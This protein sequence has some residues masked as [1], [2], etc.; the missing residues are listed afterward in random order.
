M[1]EIKDCLKQYKE[2]TL[3]LINLLEIEDYDSLES[4]LDNRQNLIDEMSQMSYTKETM[5][6]IYEELQIQQLQ[7]KLNIVMNEK[8]EE[9]KANI[10]NLSASKTARKGYTNGFKVDSL[11]LNKK[12]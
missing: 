5:N 11:F 3:K 9:I 4:V 8:R 1:Q 2:I 10:E 6:K 12:I 7:D